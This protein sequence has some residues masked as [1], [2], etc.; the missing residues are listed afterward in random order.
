MSV[1][2]EEPVGSLKGV[3]RQGTIRLKGDQIPAAF[4]REA[5]QQEQ[6]KARDETAE[7]PT[8]LQGYLKLRKHTGANTS[9]LRRFVRLT[10]ST[11]SYAR[12]SEATPLKTFAVTP[13][14]SIKEAR[15]LGD[16]EG[17]EEFE[18]FAFEFISCKGTFVIFKVRG[19]S[20][21]VQD[22]VDTDEVF[23]DGV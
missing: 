22:S 6:N 23:C 9:W 4:A 7:E 13:D 20:S 15:R 14:S 12:T 3:G 21:F 10:S 1:S 17:G 11:L 19:D 2:E 18:P 8:V 16:Q 5:V